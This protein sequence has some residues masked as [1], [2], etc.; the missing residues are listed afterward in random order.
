MSD[1]QSEAVQWLWYPYIPFGKL[2]IV[3]GDPGDGK[4]MLV[5]AIIATLTRGDLLPECEGAAEP[6]PIIFQ[7]AEDGLADTIKP[8]LESMNADCSHVFVIDESQEDLTMLDERLEKAVQETGA[9]LVVL[10]PIQGYLGGDVDMHR[11]NEV[12]PILKRVAKMAEKYGCAVLLVGHLNKA[13]NQKTSYRGLGTI[14]FRAAARSVLVVG[15]SKD[16]PT[17]RIMAQ[18]K[19]SLAPEGTSIAFELSEE[20]GFQWLGSTDATADDLLNGKAKCETKTSMME[21]ELREMLIES[22]GLPSDDLLARA[23]ELGI[24]DRTLKIAKRNLGIVS[25]RRGGHWYSVLPVQEGKGVR[26]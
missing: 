19:N 13:Q 5:L 22:G 17:I 1:I 15:R 3:H 23:Q 7:T 14:D 18:D 9:K 8:R 11:A 16:E 21:A 6:I 12:R 25:E 4:T 10:D 24:S 26:S 2:T 20:N